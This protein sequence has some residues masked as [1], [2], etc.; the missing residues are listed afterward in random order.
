[1]KA[2]QFEQNKL[3]PEL[4]LPYQIVVK[5]LLKRFDALEQIFQDQLNILGDLNAENMF[6][7]D[8]TQHRVHLVNNLFCLQFHAPN[9]SC[10]TILS[11]D[12]SYV[13][14]NADGL[15]QFFQQELYFLKDLKLVK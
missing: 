10:S 8:P 15:E 4:M 5:Q 9:M 3:K 14:Q 6:H 7:I 1:M 2:I 12:F 13:G 11:R